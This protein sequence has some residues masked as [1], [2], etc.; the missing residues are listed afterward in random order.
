MVGS[1]FYLFG[2]LILLAALLANISFWSARRFWPKL[3]AV[4]V[5]AAFLPTAYATVT[6]LLSRPKPIGLEWSEDIVQ[7]ADVLAARIDEGEGIYLWL[8]VAHIHEPRAYVL[9]WDEKLA[10]QLHKAQNKAE[11][12]GTDLRMRMPFKLSLDKEEPRFYAAPQ[13]ALPNKQPPSRDVVIH[14]SSK[15]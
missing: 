4:L 8:Q 9:P 15:G 6:D 13:E 5:T 10:R 7:E 11:E 2:L 14:Q 12:Q 1:V 3:A